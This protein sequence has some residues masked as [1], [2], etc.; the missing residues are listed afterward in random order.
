MNQ[1]HDSFVQQQRKQLEDE[2]TKV[3]AQRDEIKRKQDEKEQQL[4]VNTSI[5]LLTV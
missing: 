4:M 2:K 3:E 1:E 5:A